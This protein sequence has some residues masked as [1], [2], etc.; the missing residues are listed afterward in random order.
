[1]TTIE[2]IGISPTASARLGVRRR[3]R[4]AL[5]PVA[6]AARTCRVAFSDENGPKGG[7][8]VRCALDVRITRRAPIH[9]DGRGS[10][11]PLAL[12]VALDRLER[13]IGHVVG[14]L[15]DL[16]RRPKKYFVAARAMA[17]GRA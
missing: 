6:G 1:M 17:E 7:V 5:A 12:K 14:S 15:R 4:H 10:A 13:R 16:G 11:T 3:L 8:A 9:V 2:V